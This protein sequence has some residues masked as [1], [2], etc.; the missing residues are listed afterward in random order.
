METN[1]VAKIGEFEIC[2]HGNTGNYKN[3]AGEYFIR[4]I[5]S[6][7]EYLSNDL[8]IQFFDHNKSFY[9]TVADALE[10]IAQYLKQNA[11]PDVYR[12]ILEIEHNPKNS[13]QT[14]PLNWNFD[15]LMN[16][17]GPNHRMYQKV[18]VVNKEKIS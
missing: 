14:C 10:T 18:T 13:E 15:K 12:I 11:K 7:C 3:R 4:H 1:V 9:K 2:C 17:S 16:P 8:K 5:T 6:Y